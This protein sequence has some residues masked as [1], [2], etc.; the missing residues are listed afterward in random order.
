MRSYLHF[1]STFYRHIGGNSIFKASSLE[2]DFQV[3]HQEQAKRAN[4][5]NMVS[6]I[7]NYRLMCLP[8]T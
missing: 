5:K 8:R 3:C 1:K 7:A 4:R 2:S 6:R